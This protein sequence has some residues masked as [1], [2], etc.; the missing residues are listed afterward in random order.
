MNSYIAMTATVS[1]T[2]CKITLTNRGIPFI[3]SPASL[4]TQNHDNKDV[5]IKHVTKFIWP[6]NGNSV[7][8][9]ASPITILPVFRYSPTLT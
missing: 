2:I 5:I 3:L 9:N 7:F 1:I 6:G 4:V 8:D